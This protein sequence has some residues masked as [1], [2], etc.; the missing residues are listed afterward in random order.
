MTCP[1]CGSQQRSHLC[2]ATVAFGN[3]SDPT[4]LRA[5]KPL[6]LGATVLPVDPE[7]DARMDALVAAQPKPEP[8]GFIEQLRRDL[9]SAL[10]RINNWQAAAEGCE[11]RCK[12][13]EAQ[14]RDVT[15]E[16]DVLAR[17]IY[18]V[19]KQMG[20][21]D[22]VLEPYATQLAALILD[23]KVDGVRLGEVSPP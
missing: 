3:P 12:E 20:L 16:R 23:V 4:I 7:A 8:P 14:L 11:E 15:A 17:G 21:G 10:H 19:V 5:D 6:Y 9:E 22:A 18:A 1:A 2:C 13:R